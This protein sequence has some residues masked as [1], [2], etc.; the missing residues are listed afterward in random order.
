MLNQCLHDTFFAKPESKV[1]SI[2]ILRQVPYI[3]LH[4]LLGERYDFVIN[5]DQPAGAYWIQLRSLGEC[6]ISRT[7]QLA[8]L[9]YARGPYQPSTQP[10]TY[11]FGLPQGVVSTFISYINKD[12]RVIQLFV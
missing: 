9:R 1:D 12:V 11:D 6:G 2:V 10:P 7:Q 8:I 3:I 4:S 5:A